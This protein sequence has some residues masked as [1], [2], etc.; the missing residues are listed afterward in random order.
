MN[1]LKWLTGVVNSLKWRHPFTWRGL[2]SL[3]FRSQRPDNVFIEQ[4]D[5]ATPEPSLGITLQATQAVP[6]KN[7]PLEM[8]LGDFRFFV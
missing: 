8:A 1:S 7:G 4:I 2:T 6:G 3:G 5:L